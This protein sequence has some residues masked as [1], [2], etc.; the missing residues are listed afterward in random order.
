MLGRTW[1]LFGFT[2]AYNV[3]Q[4]CWYWSLADLQKKTPKKYIPYLSYAV[5]MDIKIPFVF[6]IAFMLPLLLILPV[7]SGVR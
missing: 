7:H 4:R 1:G 3:V 6:T 5:K 2:T